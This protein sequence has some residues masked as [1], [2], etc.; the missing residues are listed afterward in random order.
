MKLKQVLST[1]A[2][3][4]LLLGAPA[5][6]LAQQ[7]AGDLQEVDDDDRI[8]QPFNLSADRIDDM[9]VMSADGA[10]VGEIEEILVDAPGQ[11]VAVTVEVDDLLDGDDEERMV[12]LDQLRLDDDLFATD[13]S[14]RQIESLPVWDD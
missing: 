7:S 12:R 11:P 6:L 13:L 5:L 14:K 10:R 1:T 4:A 8:V 3:A 2:T 9:D